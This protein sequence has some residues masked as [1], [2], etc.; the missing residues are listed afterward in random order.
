MP[1]HHRLEQCP[2]AHIKVA[3]TSDR[4]GPPFRSSVGK[5]AQLTDRPMLRGGVWSMLRRRASH[6]GIEVG[7]RISVGGVERTGI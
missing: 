4:K 7:Q 2:G 5:T 1:S 3:G 6:A